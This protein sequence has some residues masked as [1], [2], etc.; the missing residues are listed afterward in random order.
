M[1]K[2]SKKEKPAGK[3]FTADKAEQ[4]E[5]SALAKSL[6]S[7]DQSEEAAW[8]ITTDKA[9]FGREP[10]DVPERWD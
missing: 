7:N 8:G 4:D 10:I 6:R 2:D 3:V 5:Q 9:A 1:T